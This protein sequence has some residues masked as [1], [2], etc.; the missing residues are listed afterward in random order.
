[1]PYFS[2]AEA[3]ADLK[4]QKIEVVFADSAVVTHF[5]SQQDA[6]STLAI[7]A[8]EESFLTSFSEGYGIAVK[9][10]NIKLKQQLNKGLRSF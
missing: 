2:S 10:G 5:L 9:K 7:Q 8:C 6:Q 4:Q 3:L 1:M